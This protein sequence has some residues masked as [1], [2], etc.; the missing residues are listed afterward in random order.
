MT[1]Q[2]PSRTCSRLPRPPD[3]PPGGPV[4]TPIPR[5]TSGLITRAAFWRSLLFAAGA[6]ASVLVFGPLALLT[7]LLPLRARFGFV[8]QWA[9]F[10]L[11][12]LEKTC[13]LG[14]EV[15]GREN[16]PATAAVVMC[17]HQSAWET[18]ALQTVFRPQTWVLKRELLWVPLFGWGLAALAPIAIDRR[19]GRRAMD[20]VVRQ[21]ADRLARGIWVVVFPEGTRVAPGERGRY[22]IGGAVLAEHTGSP[23]V[24]VAH[25]AGEYWPRR[26]FVKRP[27]TIRMVIGPPIPASGRAAAEI[28]ADVQ[29]WIEGTVTRIST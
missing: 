2:Q 24:P 28:L 22:R 14:F 18:L 17:K 9:R 20:Q 4:S 21:G 13:H 25:N 16:I 23:V 26:G 6:Y 7:F 12:W 29:G 3:P 11:W 15:E 8:S 27:G 10:S 5:E 1:W 19:A